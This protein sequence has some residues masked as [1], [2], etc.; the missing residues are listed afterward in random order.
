MEFC[1]T[2]FVFGF[3]ALRVFSRRRRLPFVAPSPCFASLSSHILFQYFNSQRK[4]NTIGLL[5]ID[6]EPVAGS[7]DNQST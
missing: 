6:K 7:R 5:R 4:N 2:L 1:L 3:D